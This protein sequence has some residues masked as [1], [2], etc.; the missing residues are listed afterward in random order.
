M[1]RVGMV[2]GGQLARMTHQAAIALGQTLRVLAAVR[3]RLRRAGHPR[4]GA[5][6]TTPTW[7]RCARFAAGCDVVTFDHEHVPDRAHP[8]AGRRGPHRL[9]GRRRAAVRAGQ[10]ADADP[11]RRTR[12]AGAR[13][14]GAAR[15]SA[16]A[17]PRSSEFGGEH[18]W[19]VV[20]Q[21][22][23][24]RLRRPRGVGAA[25]RPRAAVPVAGP[26][27]AGR[28]VLEA[29]V[30]MR[31][32]LAA[33]VARSP[34][35][36]A[37]AWPVVQTVQQDG[38]CVEVIAPAPGLAAGQWRR[39]PTGWR[40][41]SPASSASSA[42]WP[43]SCSRWIPDPTRPDGLLVNELAMRPHNSGHWTMDGSL[44]SQFEQH[45]RAVLDYPLGRT[46]P[47]APFTVMGNVLGGPADGPGT[48][49]RHGRAGAPPGRPV[50]TRSRC[51]CTA[52]RSG[53]VASSATSTFSASD[54][55]SCAGS[56]GWRR[57]AG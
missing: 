53:R 3:R 22:R 27:G 21:D 30:P 52:R 11:A 34:F 48:H 38:I 23:A 46:D 26:A 37:A 15:D 57:L 28:L 1:P 35:G 49:D 29:F 6:R 54:R 43:S 20:A 56:P 7:T 39:R 31:R 36:Q 44:T 2:G 14:R 45:L 42:C 32:E 19:P 5:R 16:S 40:C 47:V 18:G 13:V 12:R 8:R 24:R 9:P 33:V 55:R 4:R 17:L 41:A 10:G 51:T 25:T 50:P